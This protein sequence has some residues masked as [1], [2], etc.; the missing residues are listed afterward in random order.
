MASGQETRGMIG[1]VSSMFD[2]VLSEDDLWG[3]VVSKKTKAKTP[4]RAVNLHW[5]LVPKFFR[6]P[7][8]TR[9][10]VEYH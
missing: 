1:S 6:S 9:E 2:D 5:S 8:C 7:Q 4:N 10:G 3:L